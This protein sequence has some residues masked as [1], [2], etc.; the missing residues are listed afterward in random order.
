MGDRASKALDKFATTLGHVT[1]T[2][3]E[4][5]AFVLSI[6]I[7]LSGAERHVAR[8]MFFS[9]KSDAG[10]RDMTIAMARAR[11]L[12]ADPVESDNLKS[13]IAAIEGLSKLAGE[14]NAAIHT[15]WYLDSE[16]GASPDSPPDYW[17]TSD[18][19]SIR[20]PKLQEDAET[21]FKELIGKLQ[22]AKDMLVLATV[23]TIRY[24]A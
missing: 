2:Y 11:M 1:I 5:Q 20:H 6:F 4:A 9:I 22:T 24:H 10:Q 18:P 19:N 12:D 13:V 7:N 23:F 14:R 8:A 17:M 15:M 16:D 3:N 21:Q